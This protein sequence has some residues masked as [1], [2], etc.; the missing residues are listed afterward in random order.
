MTLLFNTTS[1]GIGHNYNIHLGGGIHGVSAA[2]YLSQREIKSI[3]I[4]KSSIAAA[5][6]GDV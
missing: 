1:T 5:A 2:Y 3:I 4:E 6:S